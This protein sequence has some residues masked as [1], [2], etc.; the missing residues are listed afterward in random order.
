MGLTH[1]WDVEGM[2][3]ST[4]TTMHRAPRSRSKWI[5]GPLLV[6][7]STA[8]GP[9]V[10]PYDASVIDGDASDA[11]LDGSDD[12]RDADAPDAG[13]A[14]APDSGDAGDLPDSGDA[15]DLPDSGDAGDLP[16]AGDA[17]DLPDSGDAGDLP[18]SGDADDLPDSG[19]AG[20]LPDA[21][22]GDLPDADAGDLPDADAGDLPDSGATQFTLHVLRAGTGIGGVASNPPGISCGTVCSASFDAGATV[23]L[24][25]S[26]GPGHRFEAWTGA[27]AG[28]GPLCSIAIVGE[29]TTTAVF[30]ENRVLQVALGA[31][32]TCVLVNPT[33]VRCFG[34]GDDGRLGY[35]DTLDRGD[36]I[37]P[38]AGAEDVPIGLPA[39][40]TVVKL[41]AGAAHTCALLST[42]AVRCWG[43]NTYGQ[44]GYGDRVHRGDTLA[45]IPHVDVPLGGA[46]A[47]DITAGAWHTCVRLSTGVVRCWGRGTFGA[48]GTGTTTDQL[49][50]DGPNVLFAGAPAPSATKLAAG[51]SHTCAA[52]I[53]GGVRC[54]GRGLMG[55]LGHGATTDRGDSASTVPLAGDVALGA[56]T[57][58][59]LTANGDNTCVRI[60]SG[61]LRCW[62]SGSAGQ[63]ARGDTSDLGDEA[64]DDLTIDVPIGISAAQVA[65]SAHTCVVT[66]TNT[67]RCWGQNANGQL[68]LG[69]TQ[70]RGDGVGP[71]ATTGDVTLNVAVRQ[72]FTGWARTCV[73]TTA[74]G[75]R[76]WGLNDHGQLGYGDLAQRGDGVGPIDTDVPLF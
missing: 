5:L 66:P 72:V 44:L 50:G 21:D 70:N 35:G 40:A 16:D 27:C 30:E 12:V 76:C 64:S 71:A 11:A 75:L 19:D 1:G 73:I 28:Q 41:V 9:I 68:G 6:A 42:R 46:T 51:G 14:D 38:P 25:A 24:I 57:I 63:H 37:G 2:E 43:D 61:A 10:L 32:H 58:E 4:M 62:G 18:D 45:T 55:A 31:S 52:L 36:G 47:G 13:D 59:E 17:G 22:A 29:V 69:D 39:G 7:L 53:T 49:R 67:L 23:Q 26:P 74:A 48:L 20:D 8:C 15:G 34:E 60:D 33:D 56:G 54:W 65:A 3:R